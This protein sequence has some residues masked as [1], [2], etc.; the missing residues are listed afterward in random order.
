MPG[1]G[2]EQYLPFLLPRRLSALGAVLGRGAR[3]GLGGLVRAPRLTAQVRAPGCR[4]LLPWRP[5]QLL[6]KTLR[7]FIWCLDRRGVPGDLG[8]LR[9]PCSVWREPLCFGIVLQIPAWWAGFR[10]HWSRLAG[11]LGVRVAC[12]FQPWGIGSHGLSTGRCT[13]TCL[14]GFGEAVLR[15]SCS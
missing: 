2:Y 8:V 3:C 14:F 5:V 1:V 13:P 10:R 4:E 15:V 12:A 11:R 6:V 9:C 7:G